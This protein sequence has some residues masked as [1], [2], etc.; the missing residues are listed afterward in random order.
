MRPPGRRRPQCA[1]SFPRG[2]ANRGMPRKIRVSRPQS[3]E[4]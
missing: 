4:T 3:R 2:Q 1:R